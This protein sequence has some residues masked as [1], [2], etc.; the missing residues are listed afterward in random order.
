[1]RERGTYTHLEHQ[2]IVNMLAE[3]KMQNVMLVGAEWHDTTAPYPVFD[4]VAELHKFLSEHPLTGRKILL[5]GS[6]SV[7]LEKLIDVL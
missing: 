1:M 3:R 7:Q 4:T 5:K 2:N 6:H